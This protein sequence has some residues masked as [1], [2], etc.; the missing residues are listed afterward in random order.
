MANDLI[1]LVKVTPI[2]RDADHVSRQD[3]WHGPFLSKSCG[4]CAANVYFMDCSRDLSTAR[5][6]LDRWFSHV[7]LPQARSVRIV[8]R[9]QCALRRGILQDLGRADVR[10]ARRRAG[11]RT[12]GTREDTPVFRIGSGLNWGHPSGNTPS[13]ELSAIRPSMRPSIARE[14]SMRAF[15]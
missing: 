5:C 14:S 13:A 2:P 8:V 1:D 11:I 12:L 10:N 15:G 6:I 9:Y 3:C 7:N 4:A